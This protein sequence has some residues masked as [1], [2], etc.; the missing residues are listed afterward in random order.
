MTWT[1]ME[2]QLSY[3]HRSL[4][5]RSSRD[6]RRSSNLCRGLVL[7]QFKKVLMT[8]KIWNQDCLWTTKPSV[9][10]KEAV[11][12]PSKSEKEQPSNARRIFNKAQCSSRSPRRRYSTRTT[13]KQEQFYLKRVSQ[14][15][16]KMDCT[17]VRSC[18]KVSTRT[19]WRDGLRGSTR[20]AIY[21]RTR[22]EGWER[23]WGRLLC[24]TGRGRWD[25]GRRDRFSRGLNSRPTSSKS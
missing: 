25:K 14:P 11:L 20:V 10:N 3:L 1:K 18:G 13:S 23:V 22:A 8:S 2:S 9:K 12:W 17:W 4:T 6:R 21:F 19:V 16:E 24:N 15:R 7:S 5:T